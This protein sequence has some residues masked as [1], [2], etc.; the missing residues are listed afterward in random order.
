MIE[1]FLLKG[2]E[3][4]PPNNYA[5]LSIELN[6]DTD[7]AQQA[8]SINDW[9]FGVMEKGQPDGA[10]MLK[11]DLN[12]QNGVGIIEGKEFKIILSNERGK[13]YT[14]FNGY[15][16][17]WKAQYSNGKVTAPA[18]ET[19]SID[20][21]ND[22]ADSFSFEYLYQQ[23][24]FSKDKFIPVPYI[25][26]KKQD[27]FEVAM[28]LVTIFLIV[29]KIRD[30][31]TAIAQLAT[32]SANPLEM[33]S[34]PRLILQ[35]I[36]LIL[37]FASLIPLI[38]RV[39]TLLVPP[40]KYHNVMT[41]LDQF[42]IGC[43]YMNMEFKSSIIQNPKF[44]G[45]VIMPE[46]YN[47]FEGNKGIFAGIA[48][49]L[50]NNNEKVGYFKGTFG[51][52]L[53]AMKTMFNAKIVISQGVLYFEP[54]DF[55][56]GSNGITIP[57]RFDNKDSFTLNHEDFYSTII[58]SF[59]AD[60][61][62]RHTIQEYKGTSVQ[63]NQVPKTAI[64]NQRSLLRNLNEARIQFALAKEKTELTLVESLLL[65]FSSGI[66]VVLTIVVTTLNIAIIAI[67]ILIAIIQKIL[68]SL[69]TV[70]IKIKIK[71]EPIKKIPTPSIKNLIKDRLGVLKMEQD[72]VSVAK[73]FLIDQNSNPRS[74]KISKN[75]KSL[76]N[77][78]YLFENYHYLKAFVEYNGKPGN[79]F[80]LKENTEFPFSFDDYE[81]VRNNNA[82][83][84]PD[85]GQGELISLK[86]NPVKQTAS[87]TYK[88]RKQYITNLK[89]DIY[90]PD[91][92]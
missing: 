82:I 63:V 45:L 59:M 53:R 18:V 14:I 57:D 26:V 80:L 33:S 29:D 91:G 43:K 65:D 4:N 22:Y 60:L 85:G 28:T 32:G 40:V 5:E 52:F 79:Q 75:N 77:A 21:L 54:F 72:Y 13:Q 38:I 23:K 20:W 17:L 58:V 15:V 41:V 39:I 11:Q 25:L 73:I 35:I 62:D 83:F 30:Q 61:Y 50:K 12:D 24:F 90:E 31:I 1:K 3:I 70:G 6:W 71:L 16:D 87:C 66:Q 9:E 84:T 88:V 36:Y 8:L 46:K 19:G 68:K 10:F 67:N 81:T 55:K 92:E 34:I 37:L 7:G 48:G 69:A 47:L 27:Y 74:T 44:K 56:L 86:F 64:F 78:R 51:D 89:L 49:D 2:T 42:E 76:I